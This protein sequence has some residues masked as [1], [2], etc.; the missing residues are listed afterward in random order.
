MSSTLEVVTS[1]VVPIGEL[2]RMVES[3]VARPSEWEPLV[4]HTADERVC[5]ILARD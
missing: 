2:Q 3:V 1:G 5:R 4:E